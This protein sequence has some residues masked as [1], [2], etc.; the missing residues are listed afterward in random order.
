MEREGEMG[1]EVEVVEESGWK[2]GERGED[3]GW[4]RGTY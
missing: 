3:G 1:M 4:G 2:R